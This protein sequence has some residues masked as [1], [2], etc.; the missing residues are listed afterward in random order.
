ME[1][2][3][4]LKQFAPFGNG[5]EAPVIMFTFSPSDGE[6]TRMGST[7]QHVKGTFAQGFEVVMWNKGEDL[8]SM[9]TCSKLHV[10]GTLSINEFAG[11]KTVNFIANDVVCEGV[12]TVTP[13]SDEDD[14]VEVGFDE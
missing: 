8:G 5:F 2:I 4:E 6:W 11:R 1:F 3:Y 12:G 7:K 10:F 14:M 9:L 13:E